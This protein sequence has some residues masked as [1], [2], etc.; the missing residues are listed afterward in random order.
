MMNTKIH[1]LS[2]LLLTGFC[3]ANSQNSSSPR[4]MFLE[5]ESYFLYEE[6]KEALPIYIQLSDLFPNNNNITFRL[7]M[8]Y[9][10]IPYE[11]V[12][13]IEYL[14][15]AS[16]NINPKHKGSSLKETGA[17]PD[18]FYY[19]G[20][21][22]RINNKLEKAIVTYKK[23]KSVSDPALF[24]HNMIDDQVRACENAM[25]L[26]KNPVKVNY[27]NL[28][29]NINTRFAENNAVVSA[30]ENTIAYSAQLQFYPAVFVS[31]K[32]NGIWSTPENIN[33][34]LAVDE[35]CFP[36]GISFDGKELILYRSNEFLGDLYVSRY[37]NGKWSKV[38]KLNG[39]INTK[40]WESH[41]CISNDGSKLYF[42]SNR[43][44]TNGGLDIYVSTRKDINKD[45]WGPAVNLGPVVNSPFNE[46]TPF[47]T[48]N[49]EKLYFSSLGHNGMGGY[50]IFFSSFDKNKNS[51][52]EP[53]NIG[54]PVNTTDHDLFF[55]PTGDGN[56]GYMSLINN[57]THGR[58]DIYKI[59]I[60]AA[61]AQ[62]AAVNKTL[63]EPEVTTPSSETNRSITKQAVPDEDK[64]VII[65]SGPNN[66]PAVDIQNTVLVSQTSTAT[67]S[68]VAETSAVYSEEES[69]LTDTAS[70]LKDE[71][72]E[73]S[74]GQKEAWHK[75]LYGGLGFLGAFVLFILFLV[76]RKR[77]RKDQ[78]KS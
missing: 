16:K 34:Q 64:P 77:K 1:I 59:K 76:W 5:A 15:K 6:Y 60:S 46:E 42:T 24:D 4:E 14:E 8:C 41:A 10:N 7:G 52:S 72:L 37:N 35:D 55:Q 53:Q 3:L 26:M 40:Y 68:I 78:T 39:N 22:Y 20:D 63:E 49:N 74:P 57:D 44:G 25:K 11:K 32:V 13:S 45:D 38:R 19:L 28:G 54:Y 31:R 73:F 18:A 67:D 47:I 70:A 17:P 30:D 56:E 48:S 62:M 12:K 69:K 43:K 75:L 51:W 58:S 2:F 23:F 21:A 9:L 50:D 61:P 36:V 27:T 33:S 66:L 71:V 29:D 65:A